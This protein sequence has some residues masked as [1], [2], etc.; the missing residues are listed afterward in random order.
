M[1]HISALAVHMFG[2]GASGQSVGCPF[3]LTPQQHPLRKVLFKAV[4][5]VIRRLFPRI[6]PNIE[7]VALQVIR[8]R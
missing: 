8:S 1:G 7:Q 4:P 3:A 5:E 2:G 6:L